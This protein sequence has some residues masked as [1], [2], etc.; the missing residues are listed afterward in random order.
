M[1]LQN[2]KKIGGGLL[3]R[4]NTFKEISFPN[5]ENIEGSILLKGIKF[6]LLISN[7]NEL[8]T[9]SFEKMREVKI[10]GFISL[11]F[12]EPTTNIV[13]KEI[14]L[15]KL[16]KCEG[17]FFKN[18]ELSILKLNNLERIETSL[19]NDNGLPSFLIENTK[20][21][22]IILDKLKCSNKISIENNDE[23]EKVSF[24]ELKEVKEKISINLN[25]NLTNLSDIFPKL[26]NVLGETNTTA[27]AIND[28][29]SLTKALNMNGSF[30]NIKRIVGRVVIFQVNAES[31][32]HLEYK[33]IPIIEGGGGSVQ[34]EE[35]SQ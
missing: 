11:D 30:N 33:I 10:I 31:K 22:N 35:F 9:V 29:S 6:G 28:S 27:V 13:L 24:K 32:K 1:F 23:L 18:P 8:K 2:L 14:N 21:E 17:L 4:D 20:L 5:L 19:D 34:I 25:K 7:N 3:I 12:D 26:Q 16:E 15:E